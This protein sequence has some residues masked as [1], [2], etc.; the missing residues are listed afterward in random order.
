MVGGYWVHWVQRGMD[1][2]KWGELFVAHNRCLVRRA[3]RPKG[4]G[5]KA[6]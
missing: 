5:R 6:K 1:P 2:E 3:L 4:R